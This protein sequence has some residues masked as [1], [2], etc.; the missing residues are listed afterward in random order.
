MKMTTYRLDRGSV[1]LVTGAEQY[2]DVDGP[3]LTPSLAGVLS[4]LGV[5]FVFVPP[6]VELHVLTGPGHPVE[7]A[8]I[9]AVR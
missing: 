4:G 9:A 2:D 7:I 6:G 5:S 1:I 8:P 3:D